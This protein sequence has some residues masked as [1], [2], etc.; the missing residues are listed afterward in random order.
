MTLVATID[1]VRAARAADA[2]VRAEPH[3]AAVAPR[4]DAGGSTHATR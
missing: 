4:A 1:P 3:A 2:D